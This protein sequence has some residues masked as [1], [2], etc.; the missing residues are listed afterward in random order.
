LL[1]A[2]VPPLNWAANES[3]LVLAEAM[4]WGGLSH[5]AV[6]GD[7]EKLLHST[8]T[9]AAITATFVNSSTTSSNGPKNNTGK[10]H[11][12]SSSV[13]PSWDPLADNIT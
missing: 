4:E 3:S 7:D 10:E 12:S 9:A 1:A 2:A 6:T 11:R 8:P 5:R 13:S